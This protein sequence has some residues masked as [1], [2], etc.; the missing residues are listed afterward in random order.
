MSVPLLRRTAAVTQFV[1]PRFRCRSFSAAHAQGACLLVLG[2]AL[3]SGNA[4]AVEISEE[5]DDGAG[6]R[7]AAALLNRRA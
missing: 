6:Q 4:A 1:S 3:Q 7:T 5:E 2:R